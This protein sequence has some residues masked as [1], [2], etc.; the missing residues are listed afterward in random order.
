MLPST[1]LKYRE[2]T[3]EPVETAMKHSVQRSPAITPSA[4]QETLRPPRPANFF[5]DDD[6]D[7]AYDAML[8]P[9]GSWQSPDDE[10]ALE[11]TIGGGECPDR[12]L[13]MEGST[14]VLDATT[15]SL[16]CS[17]A[18]Q[19]TPMATAVVIDPRKIGCQVC[20]R[21]RLQSSEDRI[22]PTTCVVSATLLGQGT[23]RIHTT[24]SRG[25]VQQLYACFAGAVVLRRC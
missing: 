10:A 12:L 2:D 16:R 21:T 13:A 24:E 1:T 7:D 17:S 23:D 3:P 14:S 18:Q 15:F 22:T 25:K 9:R 8:S 19:R 4:S 20:L 5:F 6:D 11:D